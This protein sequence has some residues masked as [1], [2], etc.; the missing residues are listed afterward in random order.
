VR[1]PTPDVRSWYPDHRP[2]YDEI[3]I[4]LGQGLQ[5]GPHGVPPPRFPVHFSKPIINLKAC[6]SA[7]GCC[8]E[9]GLGSV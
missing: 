9:M 4:V 5:A 2:V 3:A 7:A 6:V 1:I 8:G